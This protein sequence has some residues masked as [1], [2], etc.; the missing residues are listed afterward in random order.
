M[1]DTTRAGLRKMLASR[2]AYLVKRLE[3]V[4]GSRD[5]AADALH[6]TWLRLEN[7]N[8]ST[9]VTN[10]DAYILGMANNVAIDQH[11]RERRHLHDDDVETL[12]ELPDEV[13]DPE[14]IVAAR[15]KVDALKDVLRGLP[16]RRRAILLAARVDGLLNREIAERFGISLRLVES[17]LSAAM[18]YC[19]Q[20]M[21]EEGEPYTGSRGGPRKF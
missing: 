14:R 4:T 16:P 6:E 11:R 18:K 5:G 1:S 21:Q 20:R 10:A 15:R 17:E 12:L 3:R 7:A 9:Q 2:Y 8:V 13:A 19:L